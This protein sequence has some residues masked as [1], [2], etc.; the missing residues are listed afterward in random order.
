MIVLIDTEELFLNSTVTH[1]KN[2]QQT[3]HRKSIQ[4]HSI[5]PALMSS[6]ITTIHFVH[7]HNKNNLIS[8]G[9]FRFTREREKPLQPI[10]VLRVLRAVTH[11]V[12]TQ[13]SPHTTITTNPL[14]LLNVQLQPRDLCL[15]L[16]LMSKAWLMYITIYHT[17]TFSLFLHRLNCD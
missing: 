8:F 9:V 15:S 12:F 7:C 3:K 10:R 13:P 5:H 2:S 6:N 14:T 4:N 11:Q 17:I 1:D 16:C